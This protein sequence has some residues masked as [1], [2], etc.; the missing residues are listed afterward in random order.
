MSITDTNATDARRWRAESQAA[1]AA[2]YEHVDRHGIL[3]AEFR[4]F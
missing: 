4:S 3:L 1:V 2:W